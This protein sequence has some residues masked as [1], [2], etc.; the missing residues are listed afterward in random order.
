MNST[1]YMKSCAFALLLL[2]L[3]GIPV[4]KAFADEPD[5]V[6]ATVN[7]VPIRLSYVYEHIEAL[8]LGDQID[9][10]DQLNRFTESVIQEDVLF[11]FGLRRLHEDP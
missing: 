9:V 2:V 7:G 10:R 3:V 4:A 11:Q 6:V 8:P 5:P 1:T